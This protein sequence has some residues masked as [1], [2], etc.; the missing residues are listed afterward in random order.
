MAMHPELQAKA[1]TEVDSVLHDKRL[2]DM[3][4]RPSMP[5]V[6]AIVK[7]VLRWRS[8]APLGA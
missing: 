2:P 1:Q 6:H 4:D 8:V 7:E 3:D 5:Y